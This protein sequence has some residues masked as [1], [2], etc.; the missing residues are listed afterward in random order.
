M[1][2]IEIP[3]S[4]K[5]ACAALAGQ[6]CATTRSEPKGEPG[7]IF[8]IGG[9]WF[10]LL[11]VWEVPLRWVNEGAY[12]LEGFDSPEAFEKT[13]R[14]LHRGHYTDNKQYFIHFFAGCER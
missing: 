12:R 9:Q 1:A 3:F 8:E 13:W 5:M 6:K 7:D 11:D 4:P 2:V 14:S 10:R